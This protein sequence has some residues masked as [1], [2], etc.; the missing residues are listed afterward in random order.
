[1]GKHATLAMVLAV[2][3][4]QDAFAVGFDGLA[5]GTVFGLNTNLPG[6]QVHSEDDI[7]M[8]VENFVLGGSELFFF[9]EVGG[10]GSENFATN[11]LSLDNISV[12]FDFADVAF[13]VNQV[14]FEFV[15]LG[16]ASNLSVNDD[17]L[18]VLDPLSTL[19]MSVAPGVTANVESGLITLFGPVTSL[20]IVG[21]ELVIDN[22][23]AV[24]EPASGVLLVLGAVA[25][26][27]RRRNDG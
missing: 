14:S 26:W 2:A 21:Q 25:F 18:F 13:P 7:H 27:R 3:L 9:A 17:T 4:C 6:A 8:S 20:L 22:V 10:T 19:P 15:D 23:V 11:A 24:P 5:N 12:R 16:G 1:M